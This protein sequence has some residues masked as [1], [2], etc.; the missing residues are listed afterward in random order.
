MIYGLPPE[1]P[2]SD[3]RPRPMRNERGGIPASRRSTLTPFYKSDMLSKKYAI[4]GHNRLEAKA[5]AIL[6]P[7]ELRFVKTELPRLIRAN[8]NCPQCL[9]G[10]ASFSFSQQN[11]RFFFCVC[12]AGFSQP[13]VDGET[14]LFLG[15]CQAIQNEGPRIP[16]LLSHTPIGNVPPCRLMCTPGSV[17]ERKGLLPR[18]AF[19]HRIYLRSTNATEP[20]LNTKA[21][22]NEP[23]SVSQLYPCHCGQHAFGDLNPRM[24]TKDAMFVF[25]NASQWHRVRIYRRRTRVCL[26]RQS[27]M[28]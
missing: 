7:R 4:H 26:V 10:G 12:D 5:A 20:T 14:W 24:K 25:D 8:P 13:K 19:A 11:E 27:N 23:Q 15:K 16:H 2:H 3:G 21:S 6:D 1:V 9:S 18:F 17:H 22:L 28:C